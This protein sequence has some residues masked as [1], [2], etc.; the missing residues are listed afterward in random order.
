MFR[1]VMRFMVLF[2]LCGLSLLSASI[3]LGRQKA[4]EVIAYSAWVNE[5]RIYVM[6]VAMN[7]QR[8]LTG[9]DEGTERFPL[10][11]PDGTRV[12][13]Q[14][15]ESQYSLPVLVV[16]DFPTGR[17]VSFPYS[18]ISVPVWSPDGRWV[19][20]S[21]YLGSGK[22]SVVVVEPDTGMIK[23]IAEVGAAD[24]SWT[25][26]GD[27]LLFMY[28]ERLFS[29]NMDCLN[30]QD[31]CQPSLNI[32]DEV[33][34]PYP[35][36][37]W[38]PDKKYIALASRGEGG[39]NLQVRAVNCGD[40][41]DPNCLGEGITF[42]TD[43]DRVYWINWSPDGHSIALVGQHSMVDIWLY[44]NDFDTQTTRIFDVMLYSQNMSWSP[45]SQ[46]IVFTRQ[47][48]IVPLRSNIAILDVQS[49]HIRDITQP[50][51]YDLD[52]VWRP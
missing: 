49:G 19:A 1:L 3:A 4:S 26:D 32:P 28:E 50:I 44:I 31:D 33:M 20:F 34:L 7:L 47:G 46:E 41:S 5:R 29:A 42:P 8:P 12:A 11:S 22:N 16:A 27:W 48:Q 37:S 43:Y 40:L 6:D 15:A 52:P 36:P 51:L 23:V 9:I 38:S 35:K 10:W 13:F 17:S 24:I 39:V 14:R 30:T 45:D 25:P 2:W 21:G 18:M